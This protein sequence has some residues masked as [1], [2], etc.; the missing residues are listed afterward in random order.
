M[1]VDSPEQP[2]TIIIAY[3]IEIG[4]AEWPLLWFFPVVDKSP[5]HF[6]QIKTVKVAIIICFF[7]FITTKHIHFVLDKGC[8]VGIDFGNRASAGLLLF[9][10]L[11]HQIK[12]VYIIAAAPV[13]SLPTENY[14]KGLVNDS[15]VTLQSKWDSINFVIDFFPLEMVNIFWYI[16]RVKVRES[17]L[18]GIVPPMYE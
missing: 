15:R 9:P 18:I 5:F 14:Q 8:C 13:G 1:I 2:Y 3:H 10:L 6:L 16:K 17:A 11:I 12:T 4:S 7:R